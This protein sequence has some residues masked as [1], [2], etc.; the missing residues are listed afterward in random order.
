MK[1]TY[2]PWVVLSALLTGSALGLMDSTIT[3]VAVPSLI[4]D[5]GARVDQILWVGN[6]YL[7]GYAAL[8]VTAGRLGDLFGQKRMF[9]I[10]VSLFVLSSIACAFAQSAEMFVASRVVQ[11]CSAALF[12]P[13][14]MAIITHIF[15][16]E[17]RGTAFGVW[18]SVA[19]ISV[20]AGPTLGG[21]TVAA[22]GWRWVFLINVFIGAIA[23]VYAAVVVPNVNFG[24]RPRLDI[25]G[26][27]LLSLGLFLLVYGLLEGE[28]HHWGPLWG[29][30]TAPMVIVAGVCAL[31]ALVALERGRQDREPLLPFS[32]LRNRNFV[33]TLGATCGLALA[34]S[35]MLFLTLL[36]LQM[37]IGMAVAVAGITV[38]TAPAVSVL[39]SPFSG[40]LT[41]KYGGKYVLFVGMLV[42]AAGLVLLASA[43]QIGSTWYDMLP[44]LLTVGIGMGVTF[45]PPVA[46]AM[47]SV[48]KSMTGVASGCFNMARLAGSLI[49]SAS[50]G[51]LLQARL[52][53]ALTRAA[54]NH[55]NA[56]PPDLRDRFIAG[57]AT[58]S[59]GDLQ[60][61]HLT[62][63]PATQTLANLVLHEGLADAIRWTYTL[64]VA[65]L[66]IGAIAV[67][68]THSRTKPTDPTPQPTADDTPAA[69]AVS[70]VAQ[71]AVP[72]SA[73]DPASTFASPPSPAPA[74]S[75]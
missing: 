44:G 62:T 52:A 13:Q 55:A 15:P 25:A 23:M 38:A 28:S 53:P 41:D 68:G 46:M 19:G 2:S 48:P 57:F 60:T 64:P 63:E 9:M 26:S 35:S 37:S 21:L 24:R 70:A 4:H 17:R 71:A 7:L 14:S 49:G 22:F 27:V 66:V 42:L 36:N 50:V 67:L 31:V 61:Q 29:P 40:R 69:S 18:G 16:P 43:E 51:A 3:N 33:L 30:V 5:L 47:G 8:V 39:V 11:G 75:T 6:G 54:T 45:S 74:K 73:H 10:G 58:A 34:V 72:A 32:V 59:T 20:A 1:R 12:G 65:V 56:L